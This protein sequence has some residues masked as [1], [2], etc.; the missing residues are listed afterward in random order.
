MRIER[1]YRHKLVEHII[2]SVVVEHLGQRAFE[3]GRPRHHARHVTAG[4][5]EPEIMDIIAIAKRRRRFFEY[6]E[7]EIFQ[8]RN[9]IAERHRAALAIHFKPQILAVHRQA[10]HLAVVALH[11][12]QT[13]H[14]ARRL[15]DAIAAAVIYRKYRT[16]AH[17][18]RGCAL[19]IGQ[20]RKR[21]LN[22]RFPPAHHQFKLGIQLC[23]VDFLFAVGQIQRVAQQSHTAVFEADC[24]A[25][26][27]AAGGVHEHI[28]DLFTHPGRDIVARQPN[29]DIQMP[30][31]RRTDREQFGAR[32]VGER[33][34][35]QRHPF[36]L[37]K[38]KR[39][40]QVMR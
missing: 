18:H 26:Q 16:I 34:C 5:G 12:Q 27:R 4:Q 8:G 28:L 32:P 36:Q 13:D 7:T 25:Q 24:P 38:L 30:P 20:P 19:F 14:I 10:R 33:H 9:D 40:Q 11:L 29:E 6:I 31:E 35:G 37:R 3:N 23:L 2:F 39:H 17:Q 15:F 21:R 22:R 1:G